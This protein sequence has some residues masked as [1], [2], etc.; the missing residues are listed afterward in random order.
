M[1]QIHPQII[2][3]FSE[4]LRLDA[5]DASIITRYK[6]FNLTEGNSPTVNNSTESYP[7]S[8]TTYPDVEDINKDQTMS[9]IE[10]Y[11]QYKVSLK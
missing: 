6:D 7:T 2:I 8:S 3:I 5:E 4:G 9:A 10:S 1:D 11:Y